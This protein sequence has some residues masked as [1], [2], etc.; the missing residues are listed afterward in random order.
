ME[1]TERLYRIE[2]LLRESRMG[3]ARRFFWCGGV[4]PPQAEDYF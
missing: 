3:A 2:Q 4:D 1:R